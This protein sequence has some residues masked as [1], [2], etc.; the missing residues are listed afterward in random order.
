MKARQIRQQDQV[1]KLILCSG[2]FIGEEYMLKEVESEI[3][4]KLIE[5]D[6]VP[7]ES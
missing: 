6:I 5:N 7:P 1:K 3:N 2:N 4:K